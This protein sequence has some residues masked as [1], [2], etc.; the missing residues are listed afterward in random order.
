M[1]LPHTKVVSSQIYFSV[2]IHKVCIC[3]IGKSRDVISK[4]SVASV[5]GCECCPILEGSDFCQAHSLH[6]IGSRSLMS[7]PSPSPH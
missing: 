6:V 2:V 1:S 3:S 5:S 4:D 7:S